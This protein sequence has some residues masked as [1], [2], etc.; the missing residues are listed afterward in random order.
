L[1]PKKAKE[2]IPKTAE[3]LAL[4]EDLVSDVVYYY[5]E[6]IRKSLSGLKHQRI[7]VTNLGDFV[8]KHWKIDEKIEMLEKWEEK[9]KLKGMQEMTAR[10]KTAETLYDLRNIKKIVEEEGQ[11]S[12]FIKLHKKVANEPTRKHNKT[13]ENQRANTGG[14]S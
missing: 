12:A 3:C 9:N 2:L 5:W 4:S 14:D 13:L 1:R 11:R 8:I 10:F 6:E 7:H